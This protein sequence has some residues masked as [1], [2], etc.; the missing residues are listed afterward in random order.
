MSTTPLVE[1]PNAHATNP[2]YSNPLRG[3]TDEGVFLFSCGIFTDAIADSYRALNAHLA[4][5]HEAELVSLCPKL[6]AIPSRGLNEP[7]S[8]VVRGGGVQFL[9]P[10][11]PSA[12][13]VINLGVFD[14]P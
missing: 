9:L 7:P 4:E 8:E 6:P 10:S 2:Y 13:P 3:R 11:V 5:R 1:Y 14:R 12:R